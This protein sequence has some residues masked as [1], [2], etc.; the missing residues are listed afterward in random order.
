MRYDLS[1]PKCFEF[2]ADVL[3]PGFDQNDLAIFEADELSTC[4]ICGARFTSVHDFDAEERD[5][6]GELICEEC[7][8]SGEHDPLDSRE[9][10]TY[11]ARW[12]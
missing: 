6:S 8:A 7:D 3:G 1:N 10:G 2:V 9:H 4:I 12:L 11:D 5:R